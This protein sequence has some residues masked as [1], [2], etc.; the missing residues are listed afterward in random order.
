M[1]TELIDKQ[2]IVTFLN[3]LNLKN[4]MYD[5]IIIGAGPA[6]LSAAI[7][8]CRKKLKTLVITMDIGGQAS[9]TAHIENYPGVEPQKGM[10]LMET[11]RQQA[12]GFGAEFAFGKVNELIKNDDL[13]ERMKTHN[14]NKAKQYLVSNVVRDFERVYR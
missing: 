4:I 11:F 14:A 3:P 1:Q 5:T 10:E 8:T 6:G 9:L 7:Y 13:R 12:E 2:N